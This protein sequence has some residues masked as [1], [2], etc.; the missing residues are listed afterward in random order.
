MNLDINNIEFADNKVVEMTFFDNYRTLSITIENSYSTSDKVWLGKTKLVIKNW[1]EL[2]VQ[3]YVTKVPDSKGETYEIDWRTEL[4]TF[5]MIQEVIV[6]PNELSLKGF[7]KQNG[8][9]ITYLFKNCIYDI[10][11]KPN[12]QNYR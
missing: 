5:D 12:L 2:S 9:W 7:S 6:K 11:C 8:D 3:K 1:E 4:L 10:S